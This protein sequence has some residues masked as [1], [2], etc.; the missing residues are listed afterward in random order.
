M[1]AEQIKTFVQK[2]KDNNMA[3]Y[4]DDVEKLCNAAIE[5]TEMLG[6]VKLCMEGKPPVAPVT[7]IYLLKKLEE[8]LTKLA[9]KLK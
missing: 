8:F 4:D 5:M 7:D 3:P 6:L 1:S 2:V 9:E